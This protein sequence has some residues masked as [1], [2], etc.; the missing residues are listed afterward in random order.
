MG[1]TAEP[2]NAYWELKAFYVNDSG[3]ITCNLGCYFDDQLLIS[4]SRRVS[5][6]EIERA[7]TD[8]LLAFHPDVAINVARSVPRQIS[9]CRHCVTTEHSCAI[10]RSHDDHPNR[11]C[12]CGQSL[13]TQDCEPD[14]R[15]DPLNLRGRL[16]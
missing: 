14:C 7:F 10:D 2:G 3:A 4:L 13:S 5:W 1:A 12:D 15:V 16:T 6:A 9:T 11:C 8:H